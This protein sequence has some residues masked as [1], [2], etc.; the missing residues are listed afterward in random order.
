MEVDFVNEP[1]FLDVKIGVFEYYIC[2]PSPIILFCI[3]PIL[4][5]LPGNISSLG[6]ISFRPE[7]FRF[8]SLGLMG[9]LL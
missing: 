9:G 5:S 7:Y 4:S 3:L 2:G 8:F 6:L 1:I